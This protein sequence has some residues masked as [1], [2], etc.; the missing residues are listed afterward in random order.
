MKGLKSTICDT[1]QAETGIKLTP[2]DLGIKFDSDHV[3]VKLWDFEI[4]SL[5]IHGHRDIDSAEFA[6]DLLDALFDEYY[7]LREKIIDVKLDDL[8]QRLRPQVIENL[9]KVLQ[10][11]KIDKGLIETLDYEF[12]DMGY[13]KTPYS[14]PDEEE[15]GFPVIALRITDFEDLEHL[16]TIDVY[17]DPVRIDY[18]QLGKEFIKKIR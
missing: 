6:E 2:K 12:V 14:N 1:V 5:S 7:D 11:N 13:V 9:T 18:E 4:L 17:Q 10:K 8:N 16:H 15:W 3:L